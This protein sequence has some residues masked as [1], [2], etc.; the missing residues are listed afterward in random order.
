MYET[1]RSAI[2]K[3][4]KKLA[5][6]K[7]NRLSFAENMI[8]MSCIFL[9][10]IVF[11]SFF[12]SMNVPDGYASPVF[13]LAVL[14]ISRFT[15]G[16]FY[17]VFAAF[18]SV[19]FVNYFFTFPYMA[20]NFTDPGHLFTFI[21]LMIVS[22]TTSTLT[23]QAKQRDILKMENERERIRSD[24]LRAISHDIRTPLTSINGAASTLLDSE[25]ISSE[26]SRILLRDIKQQSQWLIRMVENLLSITKLDNGNILAAE[27]WAVDEVIAGAVEK[28]HKNYPDFPI[29]VEVPFEPLFVLMDPILIEQVLLNLTEN[30][31]IHAENVT[32]VRIIVEKQGDFA[33]FHVKDDGNGFSEQVLEKIKQGNIQTKMSADREGKRNM[34]L[35]IRVCSAV[36]RAHGGKLYAQNHEDGA[37]V[38]F[39]LPLS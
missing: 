4:K 11:C 3:G 32:T 25:D 30:A 28:I 12:K 8:R 39:T 21:V 13:N 2:T 22:L 18:F 37:E 17:G 19:F 9:S 14:L 29:E 31:I 27:E 5:V 20:M 36:V 24:L 38:T 10:A 16:Y 7:F 15:D 33:V 6:K 23:S 1:L 26:E 35:G 34:G